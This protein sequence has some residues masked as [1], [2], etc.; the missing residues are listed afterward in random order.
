MTTVPMPSH[1]IRATDE[2]RRHTVERLC[3]AHADGCLTL[4]EF[5][6][7]VTAAWAARTRADLVGLTDDLPPYRPPVPNIPL[8]RDAAH[9]HSTLRY[10]TA[11]WLILS[12]VS[13]GS[14][15]LLGLVAGRLADP[16]W[17]WVVG[18]AAAI[19]SGSWYV[20]NAR[21]VTAS[22]VVGSREP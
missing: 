18:P 7:R 11:V 2:E 9:L 10:L 6:G 13:V 8:C 12:V 16:W 21:N 4:D 5:D 20:A 14:W 19:L 15:G 1:R 22:G 17:I 3:R